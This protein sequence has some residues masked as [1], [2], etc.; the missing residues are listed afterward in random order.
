[1]L[2]QSLRILAFGC[3]SVG[4]MLPG[5]LLTGQMDNPCSIGVPTLASG[6]VQS[7]AGLVWELLPVAENLQAVRYGHVEIFLPRSRRN[8]IPGCQPVGRA[9][10]REMERSIPA[11][12]P[13]GEVEANCLPLDDGLPLFLAE[14]DMIWLSISVIPSQ[15]NYRRNDL[16]REL[17][18]RPAPEPH[19]KIAWHYCSR[20]SVGPFYLYLVLLSSI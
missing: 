15:K 20:Q 12:G 6:T 16:V 5:D 18:R 17:L 14:Y 13:A 1:M 11:P 4:A 2:Q 8:W 19:R 7:G 10:Y 9:V 3:W